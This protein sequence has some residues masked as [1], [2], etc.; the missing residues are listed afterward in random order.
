MKKINSADCKEAIQSHII[1]NPGC[2]GCT[3][4]REVELELAKP[5]YWKRMSITN[6]PWEGDI[7]R[8]FVLYAPK[9]GITQ[10][11]LQLYVSEKNGILEVY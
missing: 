11:E 5:K 10:D 6:Y 4:G 1:N 9:F 8:T 3:L 7:V 2:I